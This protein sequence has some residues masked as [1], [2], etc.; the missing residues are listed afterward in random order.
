MDHPWLQDP[1]VKAEVNALIAAENG[2]RP[3]LISVSPNR[4]NHSELSNGSRQDAITP[5]SAIDTTDH[6]SNGDDELLL[7]NRVR[8][9]TALS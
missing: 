6:I 3:L 5:V 4:L 8:L 2:H 7:S 9:F 1:S